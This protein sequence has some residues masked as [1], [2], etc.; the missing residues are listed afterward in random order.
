MNK[1]LGFIKNYKFSIPLA[2]VIIIVIIFAT[3]G[4]P[5]VKADTIEATQ[6]TISQEVSVTGRVVPAENVDLSIESGGKVS[7]IPVAVGDKVEAGQTLL[8]VDSASLQIRL[9]RQQA[10]LEKA[11]LALAQQQPKTNAADDLE[12]AY[13]DGFNAVADAFLDIPS[14]VLGVDTMLDQ[15]YLSDDTVRTSYG[16]TARR[17][18][19]ET[20]L[21]F[22]EAYDEYQDVLSRYKQ[23][24]RDASRADIERLIVDT[25]D[26]VRLVAD[27]VK[28]ANTFL[29]V[30]EDKLSASALTNID[31]DQESLAEYTAET[32]THLAALLDVKD[33]IKDSQEGITDEGY[34]ITN[35]KITVRQAELDIQDTLVQIAE[36]SIKSPSNGIVTDIKAKVGETI[37]SG[38]PVVSVIS[39]NQYEIEAS[40]PEA[41]MAR[42]IVG[43]DTEVT[44]DAYSSDVIFAAKVVSVNPAETLVDGVATYK[45]TFQFTTTDERIRSG[46]TASLIIKGEKKDNVIA[47][48]QRSVITRGQ[49]R[50]VQILEGE[51]IVE[52]PVQTGLRGSDGSI[53]IVTGVAVGE[54]VVVFNEQ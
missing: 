7:S 39:E 20:E 6:T 26:A 11:K 8:R 53:E 32:N 54:K 18:R 47:V 4:K 45:T 50:F 14:I 46:M 10:D 12:K 3:K 31:D 52:R 24:T 21:K 43:A 37:S 27:S 13:E 16:S 2:I 23:T 25:Y 9:G 36:R 42:V 48:P 15:V 44:L 38:L 17:L 33:T 29:D 5:Q 35:A 28:Q 51:T 49:Q 34:D 22:N 1:I 41:D 30:V 19:T 40:I